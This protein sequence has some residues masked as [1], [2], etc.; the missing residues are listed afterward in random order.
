MRSRSLMIDSRKFGPSD[1]SH[2]RMP[3]STVGYIVMGLALASTLVAMAIDEWTQLRELELITGG[4]ALT[5]SI[6]AAMI[7]ACDLTGSPQ[8]RDGLSRAIAGSALCGKFV[9]RQGAGRHKVRA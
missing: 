2:R 3:A 1:A 7:M 4:I 9:W 5:A 8:R 6:I